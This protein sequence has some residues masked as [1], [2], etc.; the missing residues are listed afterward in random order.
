MPEGR[1]KCAANTANTANVPVST[2]CRVHGDIFAVAKATVKEK[3]RVQLLSQH[4]MDQYIEIE[5]TVSE[6]NK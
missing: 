2:Y 3:F 6:L 5:K 1:G 4:R